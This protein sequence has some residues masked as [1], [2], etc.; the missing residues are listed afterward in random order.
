MNFDTWT[1]LS[2]IVCAF[3]I[4]TYRWADPLLSTVD[5]TLPDRVPAFQYSESGYG[6][7]VWRMKI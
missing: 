1:T 3:Q 4:D 5:L 7:R 6:S 2:T